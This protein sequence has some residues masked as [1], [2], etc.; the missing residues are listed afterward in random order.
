MRTML[1]RARL[2][3]VVLVLAAACSG[4]PTP[5]PASP[6]A[7]L[8]VGAVSD[9]GAAVRTSACAVVLCGPETR[10][11]ETHGVASCVPIMRPRR[12]FCG[13]IGAIRCPDGGRC[14]DD[15]D[16]ECDP[17]RGGR[18]CGGVCQPAG[19]AR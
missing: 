11:E 19:A 9:A 2:V 8:P 17:A 3:S 4:R 12:A 5:A 1:S 10:C 6:G 13:G 18:D 14:V 7:P 16:D 15:A